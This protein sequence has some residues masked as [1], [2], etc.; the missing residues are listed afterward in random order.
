MRNSV[1][2]TTEYSGRG[3]PGG[4]SVNNV[5]QTFALPWLSLP[6]FYVF[7]IIFVGTFAFH[8]LLLGVIATLVATLGFFLINR[9]YPAKFSSTLQDV[10]YLRYVPWYLVSDTWKIIAVAGKDLLGIKSAGSLFRTV[11]F[12]AG[13]EDDTS[14]AARRVLAVVYT[15]MTPGTVVLGINVSD[16]KMLLHE[17]L[18]S[19]LPKMTRDLGAKG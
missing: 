9:R 17:L 5:K 6:I 18:R 1:H 8:E 3:V 10:L 2:D 15:T 12:D 14:A 13:T 4:R 19:P 16:Q 7:W 11:Q